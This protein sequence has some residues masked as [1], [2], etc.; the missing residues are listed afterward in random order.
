[1]SDSQEFYDEMKNLSSAIVS[2]T[3]SGAIEV[4]YDATVYNLNVIFKG[5]KSGVIEYDTVFVDDNGDERNLSVKMPFN[6]EDIEL[7]EDNKDEDYKVFL[8]TSSDKNST[9]MITSL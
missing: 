4:E 8:V 9:I 2:L 5:N 7:I 6:A 3:I 1:M